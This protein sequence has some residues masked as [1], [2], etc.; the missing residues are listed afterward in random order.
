MTATDRT[1]DVDVAVVG[2]GAV[3]TRDVPDYTIVAGVPA[4]PLRQRFGPSV[5]AALKRIAW[6]HWT[7][8]QLREALTD[9][10]TLDAEVFCRRYDLGL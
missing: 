9:F 2:A 3:V 5:Q 7:H 4:C 8:E 6:W 1:A 10:R